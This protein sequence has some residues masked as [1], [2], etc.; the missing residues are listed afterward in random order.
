[1][2]ANYKETTVTGSRWTRCA[3]VTIVN[4]FNGTPAIRFD[5][6]EV[7]SLGNDETMVRPGTDSI[8]VNFDPAEVVQLIDPTTGAPIDG[9][10][11]TMAEIYTAIYSAYLGKAQARDAAAAA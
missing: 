3:V 6:E 7:L 9:A 4:P 2:P 11:M 5:E 8:R 10:V 1:M